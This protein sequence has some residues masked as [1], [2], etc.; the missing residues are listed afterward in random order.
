MVP[1]FSKIRHCIR[2]ALWVNY[3][4]LDLHTGD[5]SCPQLHVLSTLRMWYPKS[6]S[7]YAGP[8]TAELWPLSWHPK[9]LW[10]PDIWQSISCQ[11]S[12][13]LGF[14][15]AELMEGHSGRYLAL[16]CGV[17]WSA[18]EVGWW[19]S[20]LFCVIFQARWIVLDRLCCSAVL[21]KWGSLGTR[22]WECWEGMW[23]FVTLI[24]CPFPILATWAQLCPSFSNSFECLIKTSRLSP[25]LSSVSLF[26]QCQSSE[27]YLP[28]YENS[29]T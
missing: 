12:L 6:L 15:N 22:T 19:W 8:L 27:G 7:W 14:S 29:G 21:V 28:S 1:S 4:T 17:S 16:S 13:E 24:Y 20:L 18:T 10:A 5:I 23:A 25:I 9:S 2:I 26:L 3:L 11:W